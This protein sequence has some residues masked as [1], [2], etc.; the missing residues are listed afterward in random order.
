MSDKEA[1]ATNRFENVEEVDCP[2]E[3]CDWSQEYINDEEGRMMKGAKA[4][5]HYNREHAG[6]ARVK[7]VLEKTVNIGDR[8]PHDLSDSAHDELAGEVPGYEVAYA[9]TEVVEEASDHSKVVS[10]DE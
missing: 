8:E 5:Q 10:P 1:D 6:E 4:E 7:V 9:V 3:A 2:F